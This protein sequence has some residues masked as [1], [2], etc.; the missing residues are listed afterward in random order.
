MKNNNVVY[1]L[2]YDYDYEKICV[3]FQ[4]Q[5]RR[6]T[7]SGRRD[8]GSQLSLKKAGS[9][10]HQPTSKDPQRPFYRDDIFYGGS[11]ARLPHY[12]SQV[13]LLFFFFIFRNKIVFSFRNIFL[14]LM[15][16]IIEFVIEFG[17]K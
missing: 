7:I 16:M 14:F 13:I 10:R 15:D 11:L 8:H 5:V 9:K 3:I 17:V 1:Y 2:Y 6:H 4:L 12:K